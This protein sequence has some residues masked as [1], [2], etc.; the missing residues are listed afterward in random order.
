MAVDGTDIT[1]HRSCTLGISLWPNGQCNPGSWGHEA[2]PSPLPLATF[3]LSVL[4][5]VRGRAREMSGRLT[6]SSNANSLSEAVG[7][8]G[9]CFM[10][11]LK[12]LDRCRLSCRHTERHVQKHLTWM[13]KKVWWVV[14]SAFKI[15][16]ASVCFVLKSDKSN[17]RTAHRYRLQHVVGFGPDVDNA[18]QV[19]YLFSWWAGWAHRK[20]SREG[21]LLDAHKVFGDKN[22]HVNRFLLMCT[23]LLRPLQRSWILFPPFLN[24]TQPFRTAYEKAM[25]DSLLDGENVHSPKVALSLLCNINF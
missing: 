2:W 25:G 22:S 20:I 1:L 17:N 23:R 19:C 7:E 3:W 16:S 10:K 14:Q 9:L 5:G 12:L 4:Y 6:F 11:S 8:L 21:E 13:P 15:C 24:A 18:L